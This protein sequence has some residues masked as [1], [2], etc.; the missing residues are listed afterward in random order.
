MSSISEQTL[1]ERF[2]C[3]DYTGISLLI[4]ASIMTTEYTA[5]YCEPISRWIY[6]TTTATCKR[7]FGVIL[8]QLQ[9][10][11]RIAV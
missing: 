5:F 9:V 3:V 4:A 2:A 10:V 1:M 6:I 11:S 8:P 7:S